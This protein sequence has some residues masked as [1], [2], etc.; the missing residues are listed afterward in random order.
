MTLPQALDQAE[1]LS[2][3]WESLGREFAEKGR[4][5]AE[6]LAHIQVLIV[7]EKAKTEE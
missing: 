7:I 1:R 5:F 2:K 3:E 6:A 4:E